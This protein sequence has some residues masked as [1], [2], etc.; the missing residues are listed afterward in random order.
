M[1]NRKMIV[2]VSLIFIL[3]LLLIPFSEEVRSAEKEVVIGSASD[4][5]GPFAG[6]ATGISEGRKGYVRYVNEKLGGIKGV[7]VKII[8]V[9]TGFNIDR[10]VSA[11]KKFRDEDKAL[12]MQNQN[13]GA[14]YAIERIIEESGK[15]GMARTHTAA[16]TNIFRGPGSWF[17]ASWSMPGD[18]GI[19]LLRWWMA[20]KWIKKEKPKVAIVNSDVTI[21]H[22]EAILIRDFLS[23]ANIP[24]VADFII[25]PR[26]MDTT[27]FVL[28]IKKENADVVVGAQ[29]DLG[30]T[31]FLKDMKR[32][33]LSIPALSPCCLDENAL[34]VLGDSALGTFV[35]FP[36]PLWSDVDVPAVS[37]VHQ[38]FKEWYPGETKRANYAFFWGWIQSAIA[39]EA[40]KR[41]MDKVGY[42][43]LVTDLEK[44]RKIVRDV[45]ENEMR[46]YDCGGM[47]KP[48]IYKPDDHRAFDEYRIYQVV[49][50]AEFK[51]VGWSKGAT[52]RPEQKTVKWWEDAIKGITKK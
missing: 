4:L 23:H 48:L 20:N 25:S 1:N 42:E 30:Y 43:G 41:A 45:M 28:N 7:R 39:V 3:S 18:A 51:F 17:F 5:T 26:P 6:S 8:D 24:I 31:T 12:F 15:G 2:T 16:P 19:A 36:A 29:T 11:F 38:L 27:S 33:G 21:G 32:Y 47:T 22:L 35:C 37:F 44:G 34:K 46:G 9:D 10:E 14:A 52:L 49:P 50:G 13:S 40:I